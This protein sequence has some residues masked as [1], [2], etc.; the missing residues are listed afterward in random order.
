LLSL[1]SI[2]FVTS[3]CQSSSSKSPTNQPKEIS[4][5]SGEWK[6]SMHGLRTSLSNL[7]PMLFEEK[8]FKDPKNEA[9][10]KKEIHNLALDSAKIKHDPSLLYR[11]P[12][13]RFL[14]LNF[15]E[16][17]KRAEETF[18]EGKKDFSRYQLMKLT[19]Y[20]VE[21]HTRTRQGSEFNFWKIDPFASG[22]SSVDKVQFLIASRKFDSAF[23]ESLL[24]LKK[25]DSSLSSMDLDKLANLG[26]Q[27]AVQYKNSEPMAEELVQ[28]LETN[29]NAPFYLKT[30]VRN[31]KKSLADWKAEKNKS[32]PL[33]LARRLLAKNPMEVEA[34]RSIHALLP[35]LTED[36]PMNVLGETL[37]LTGISYELLNEAS[38]LYLHENYYEACIYQAPHTNWSAQCYK[39]LKDSAIF[40]F[41]GSSGTHI[42][43][44]VQMRLDKMKALA[45]PELGN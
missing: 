33:E 34:M 35:L 29:K 44:D 42:P 41:S 39:K 23:N 26:L 15:A 5:Q 45:E 7:S 30:K 43:M 28:V 4:S 8:K 37:L 25:S 11:D 31:W 36:L 16:D 38:S 13:V 27:V 1:T 32:S 19:S 24:V 12:T 9:F 14:S 20:C 22:M 6:G 40:G 17:S 3:G 2:L 18:Q 10:I 21:C